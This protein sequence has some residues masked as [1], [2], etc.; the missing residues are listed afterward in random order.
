MEE[1]ALLARA[2]C[3]PAW[4]AALPAG[5]DRVRIGIAGGRV[6]LVVAAA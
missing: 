1:A 4:L 3:R 5:A 6:R 2:S